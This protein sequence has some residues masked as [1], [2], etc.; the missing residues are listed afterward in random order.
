MTTP[1]NGVKGG[2]IPLKN[3][4]SFMAMTMKLIDREPHLDNFAVCYG[5]SGYG[6]TQ[7]AIFAQNKTRAVVVEIFDSWTRKTF[8]QSL[9]LELGIE[10]RGSVS[11]MMEQA[12]AAL[13]DDPRRP[14]IIDEA[15]KVV[16]KGW[17][18]LVREIGM[19]ARCPII[20]VGEER[21]P[22][23]LAAFERLHNRVI[24]WMPAEPCDAE[25]AALLAA[26]VCPQ[27]AVAPDLLEEIRRQ[28]D[29]RA[30]RI[31]T[32][33]AQVGELAR[34]RGLQVVDRA[35]WGKTPFFTST[36][37]APRVIKPFGGK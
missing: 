27:V 28:S 13:G 24:E 34:N 15:D 30:R 11:D 25:D 29:G 14:L 5:P 23:K 3:V 7:S 9:L 19:V 22:Q 10:A 36:P 16:D 21:L 1:S 35:A 12:K 31:V 26:A 4:A 2:Q 20:L 6:K 8:A 17:T 32:N 33:L 37:P 18:E